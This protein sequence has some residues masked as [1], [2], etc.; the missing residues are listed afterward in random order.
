MHDRGVSDGL[1]A[2][3]DRELVDQVMRGLGQRERAIVVLHYFLG[4]PLADV[5]TTLGIPLGTVK[6]RLHRALTEMRLAIDPEPA[7][8]SA[9]SVGGE[10]A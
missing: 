2:D 7:A 4:Y 10:V 1:S 5:A 9:R 6:S 8:T 3:A